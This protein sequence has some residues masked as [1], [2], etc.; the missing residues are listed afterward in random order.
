MIFPKAISLPMSRFGGCHNRRSEFSRRIVVHTFV[1]TLRRRRQ[2]G[3]IE[4]KLRQQDVTVLIEQAQN[5]LFI[6]R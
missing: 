2:N 3:L 4:A 5:I 1:G 6:E